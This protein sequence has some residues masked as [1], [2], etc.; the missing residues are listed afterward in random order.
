LPVNVQK[1]ES[2]VLQLL[3]VTTFFHTGC[4]KKAGKEQKCNN[5]K[6]F[7]NSSGGIEHQRF[8]NFIDN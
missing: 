1:R 6:S 4:K 7:C 3:K 5:M 8:C 2:G